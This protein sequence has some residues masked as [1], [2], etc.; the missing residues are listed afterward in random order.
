MGYT[1]QDDM[2]HGGRPIAP[3]PTRSEMLRVRVNEVELARWKL[4][5]QIEGRSVSELIRAATADRADRTVAIRGL[6][7]TDRAFH[8]AAQVGDWQRAERLSVWPCRTVTG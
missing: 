3:P 2:D 6:G 4:A 8:E 1:K 5:A 7:V